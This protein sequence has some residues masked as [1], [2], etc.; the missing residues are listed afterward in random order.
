M[1]PLEG[2]I[3]ALVTPFHRG[4][5]DERSF[6]RLLQ[7]QLNDGVDGFVV[8]GT[9]AESPCLRFGE[10]ERLF[11]IARE[12]SDGEVLLLLGTGSNCT[13]RTIEMTQAA[14]RWGADAALVVTPYYNKPPQRGL[15]EHFKAIADACNIPIVLY[16]VPSRTI[17][18]LS[19]ETVAELAKHPRIAGIKEASGDMKALEQIMEVVPDDFAL[20]SGDDGTCVEFCR[21]GGHGVIAVASHLIA[22]EMKEAL[23]RA[24][25]GDKQAEEDF[26]HYNPL[27]KSLYTE[28]NPIPV[29][30][31]VYLRGLIDSSEMRL[32][33]VSLSEEYLAG[34]RDEMQKLGKIGV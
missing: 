14:V 17:T 7:S 2:V 31:A 30:S 13:R 12:E 22:V 21:R 6:R 19:V 9:T 32:P 1:K 25:A 11:E 28:A 33:L 20:L 34:L 16:N 24:R 10:I 27:I 8:N 5:V 29:K 4:E 18:A 15:V 23:V 3:T 26:K